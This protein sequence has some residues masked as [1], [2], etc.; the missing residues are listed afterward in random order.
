MKIYLA[1]FS[2]LFI[3]PGILAQDNSSSSIT[4]TVLDNTTKEPVEQAGIRI[5]N[6]KDSTYVSGTATNQSG[7]F[8]M[9]VKPGNYIVEVSF[10]GYKNAFVNVNANKKQNRLGEIFLK[11]DGILLDEAIVV[12][13][14]PEIVVKGDTVEYNADSYKVQESAV[15]EDLLKKM[16]GA[17]VDSEGKI[18]INGKEVKKILVDGKEF[19]SD[20]PKVASKN[21]PAK[22]VDKLQVLD[23]KSDMALMTGFDDGD[24]ETVINLTVK[25]GMKQGLFGSAY[26]GAG[27]HGRYEGNA[28]ANYMHN[29]NQFTVLGGTNNTN[30]ASFSD[31]ATS[32]FS[33]MRGGGRGMNFGGNNGITKSM[34]G[35]GNFAMELSP[36]LKWGG[37]VRYGRTDNDVSTDSYTQNYMTEQRG[38]DQ[39]KTEKSRGNNIGDNFNADLRFEWALD[40][41]TQVIF[42][43]NIRYNKNDNYQMGDY[44]TTHKDVTDSINWGES[45]YYSKGDGLSL[46]GTLEVSRK[47][48]KTGRVLSFSLSGGLSNQKNEGYN[49]S[50]TYFR[51]SG[52]ATDSISRIDQI[53]DQKDKGHNWR[54]YVSYVEPIGHNNF[55]QLTY[56]YRKSYSESD[57]NT[58]KMDEFGEYTVIDTASTRKMENNFINQQI[59]LNFKSVREKYNY[60]IG[61]AFQPSQS[62]SWDI[63]PDTS[64]LTKNSVFNF[65]PVAQFNYIWDKRTNLRVDYNGSTNQPT[66]SQLSSAR[67]ESN[68][69]NITYG[70][71]DLKP[72]FENKF[73]VRYRK[74]NPEQASAFMV[75]GNFEFSTNDIVSYSF[76]DDLGKQ[77]RTYKN[78][79]G[80]WKT[81]IRMMFNRPLRNKKFSI[82][83]MSYV[84]YS[85]DNG[86]VNGYKNTVKTTGFSE[87]LGVEYRSDLFD[88]GMRGNFRVSNTDNTLSGQENRTVYN[89]GGT[90]NTTVYLPYDFTVESDVNYSANSG[91]TSGY[92]Q[93]EWLWNASLSKQLF[94]AKN[95]TIRLKI[96]DILQQRS[97]ISQSADSRSYKETITNTIN[98][99]FMVNFVYR[100]Q[101]FKGGA[102]RG[103]MEQ[104]DRGH[105]GGGF[106]GGP[107]RM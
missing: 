103:D 66:T 75:S 38:G 4:G 91:Y 76:T 101:I 31:F 104:R 96:Y 3:M 88:F 16:P 59:G 84:S 46:S 89:Y 83:S 97:N 107:P 48:G 41:A 51:R 69:M 1:F 47:L 79:N 92:K 37:N 17:E 14:A 81:N 15:V 24:D 90:A 71:P 9:Q 105:G 100:F 28:M 33:G 55:L 18:T 35:G 25:P 72:A 87:N 78:V 54:G 67:D 22:M 60:T 85:E 50:E 99:Y 30:N 70:N 61:V 62:D 7:R 106:R 20:D 40:S 63:R 98:S 21:L 42:R 94:K 45:D 102:S 26:A 39:Y 8:S 56:S 86:Y 44:L 77:T 32:S 11:D 29:N 12:A 74:F 53:F 13:K 73:R 65:A 49:W 27:S 43:P 93:N 2:F 58:L 36:K 19:F 52:I 34:N 23:R 82:N 64:V 10:L 5:L 80:N 57:K 95:G 6:S 68:P